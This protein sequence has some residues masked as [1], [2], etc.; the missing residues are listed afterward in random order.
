MPNTAPYSNRCASLK[1]WFYCR[2]SSSLLQ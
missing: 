1:I 2:I